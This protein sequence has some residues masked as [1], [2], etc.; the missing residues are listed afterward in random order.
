M[1]IG[2][3]VNCTGPVPLHP[4]NRTC[5]CGR[6]VCVGTSVGVGRGVGIGGAAVGRTVGAE[7]GIDVGLGAGEGI[8]VNTG[9]FVALAT[10][11]GI[12]ADV[13]TG[14]DVEATVGEIW[15]A[16]GVTVGG[17]SFEVQD[18]RTPRLTRSMIPNR[19]IAPVYIA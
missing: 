9:T 16:S 11:V 19:R 12:G 5:C 18:A 3:C 6:G 2:D 7:L 13:G 4:L 15:V 1:R 8:G 17:T 14:V 10:V